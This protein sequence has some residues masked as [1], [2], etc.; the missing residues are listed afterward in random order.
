MNMNIQLVTRALSIALIAAVAVS[1]KIFADAVD[2]ERTQV[3]K[4]DD[5][6]LTNQAGAAVVYKRIRQAAERVCSQPGSTRRLSTSS[7]Q[8]SCVAHATSQAVNDVQSEVLYTYYQKT[9]GHSSVLV[10]QNEVK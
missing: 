2:S 1:P 5:V 4:F 9:L 7:I 10:V 6:N 3:V 8:E